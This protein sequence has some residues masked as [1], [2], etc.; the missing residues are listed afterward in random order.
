[1]IGRRD[2]LVGAAA[3]GLFIEAA[4]AEPLSPDDVLTTLRERI[5]TTRQSVGIVAATFDANTQQTV[6]Y[7]K[8]DSRNNR[9]LDGD[10]V[11]EIGSITKVWTATLAMQLADEGLLDLD[12]PVA[13][14]LPQFRVADVDVHVLFVRVQAQGG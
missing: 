5:D 9:A 4:G 6:P 2:F 3:S 10:T 12:R 11:F 8:S 7:G 13:T 1:M 14:Y